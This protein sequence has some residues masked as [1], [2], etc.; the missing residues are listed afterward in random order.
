MYKTY[1]FMYKS[2]EFYMIVL[3]SVWHLVWGNTPVF[4][5]GLYL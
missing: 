1:K 4:N 3:Q 5:V 2:I